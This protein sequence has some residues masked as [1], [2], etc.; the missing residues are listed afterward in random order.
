VPQVA[1][2]QAVALA[3]PAKKAQEVQL[4]AEAVGA[5]AEPA[6]LEAAV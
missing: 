5:Q 6:P 2:V 1:E 4:V 3:E